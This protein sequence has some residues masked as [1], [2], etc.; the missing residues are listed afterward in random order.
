VNLAAGGVGKRRRDARFGLA[1]A[2]RVF[3]LLLSSWLLVEPALADDTIGTLTF[4]ARPPQILQKEHGTTFTGHAFLIIS[5]WTNS[6]S[7]EEIF[8]FYP[9]EGSLK[10]M[11]KGPGM[12]KSEERCGPNDDCG[13]QRRAELLNRLSEA[14]ESV[15]V[16]LTLEQRA[17][18]YS[19]IKK[20]D[21][22]ST[23]S[24]W[25]QIVPSSDTEY[26]LFDSNCIDFI[27]AVASRLGYP[28]PDRFDLQTPTQFMAAFKPLAA[29]EVKLREA[30]RRSD[31]MAKKASEAEERARISD[32]Q[33][34]DAEQ[35]QQDAEQRQQ[36]AEKRATLAEKTAADLR[37]AQQTQLQAEQARTQAQTIPAGWVSCDCPHVH[38]AYGKWV[39][40]VLYHP[41]NI[42]CP[43]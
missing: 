35:R 32:K 40:G 26:R 13:P 27:A 34:Q 12:L 31:E 18:V 9:V 6:G 7:K 29:Q 19:E 24:G 42:K 8:G 28:T 21:S 30:H 43:R 23:S 2:C 33:R 41:D 39:R 20:W 4:V 16:P 37:A 11:I 1:L 14:K 36:E 17:A 38:S 25:K 3:G 5:L 15:A 10:G 22:K